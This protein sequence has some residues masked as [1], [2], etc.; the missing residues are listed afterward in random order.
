MTNGKKQMGKPLQIHC[1]RRNQ[2]V[3]KEDWIE[4]WKKK[5][6]KLEQNG[7]KIRTFAQFSN[8]KGKELFS[9]VN[10]KNQNG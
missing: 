8:K 1:R 5:K 3:Q 7:K 6:R 9:S 4:N 10:A 2:K